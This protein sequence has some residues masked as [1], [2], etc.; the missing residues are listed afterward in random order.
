MRRASFCCEREGCRRRTTPAPVRFLGPR[1]FLGAVVVLATALAHGLSGARLARLR[2]R[3]G[4]SARTLRRWQRW[5]RETF[6]SSPWWRVLRGRLLPPVR[7]AALPAALLER[8]AGAEPAARLTE[9]LRL[10]APWSSASA[11]AAL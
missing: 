7:E 4:V 10:L 3:F 6:A 2:E 5:W 8:C 1:V 11:G 9:L